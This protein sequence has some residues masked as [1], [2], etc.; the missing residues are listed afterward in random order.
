MHVWVDF[1]SNPSKILDLS[2]LVSTEAKC[3]HF[4]G[5]CLQTRMFWMGLLWCTVDGDDLFSCDFDFPKLSV[6]LVLHQMV[7]FNGQ[8]NEY[9]PMDGM[10]R[11]MTRSFKE[12]NT[13]FRFSWLLIW[14]TSLWCFQ[15]LIVYLISEHRF[16]LFGHQCLQ[17][18]I[19]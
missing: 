18:T 8:F 1:H 3:S 17:K 15:Q 5:L 14:W 13:P 10:K 16:S 12:I 19:F 7:Q 2:A 9:C 11:K 4:F 6:S